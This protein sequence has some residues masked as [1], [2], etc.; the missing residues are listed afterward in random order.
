V[1][2][3]Q[4]VGRKRPPCGEL[5]HERKLPRGPQTTNEKTNEQGEEWGGRGGGGWKNIYVF[6][7]RRRRG[8]GRGGRSFSNAHSQLNTFNPPPPPSP[9]L[10]LLPNIYRNTI[11]WLSEGTTCI[12]QCGEKNSALPP[13]LSVILLI[14]RSLQAI[15]E[16]TECGFFRLLLLLLLLPFLRLLLLLLLLP[17]LLLLLLL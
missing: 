14:L 4:T 9:P 15:C 12:M 17:F 8:V 11:S 2:V 13:H 6:F 3:F 5:L 16:V 1:C 10:L 7:L